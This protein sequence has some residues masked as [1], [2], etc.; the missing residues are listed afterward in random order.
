M[1]LWLQPTQEPSGRMMKRTGTGSDSNS[2]N[3]NVYF[4][5]NNSNNED[6]DVNEKGAKIQLRRTARKQFLQLLFGMALFISTL[7]VFTVK[8]HHSPKMRGGRYRSIGTTSDATKQHLNQNDEDN[9]KNQLI[10]DLPINSIYRLSM[11]DSVTGTIHSL[12]QYIGMITLIVNT[13][14][15]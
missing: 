13:A 14:C 4:V 3:N 12:H 11:K 6:D 5:G 9:D 8:Y 7:S 2:N 15:K 10:H 1:L